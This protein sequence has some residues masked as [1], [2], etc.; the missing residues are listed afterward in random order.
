MCCNKELIVDYWKK[1]TQ[2][3]SSVDVLWN[4]TAGKKIKPAVI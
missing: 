1:S 3:Q 2:F 4:W